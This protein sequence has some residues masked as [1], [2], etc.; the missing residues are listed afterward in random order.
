MTPVSLTWTPLIWLGLGAI[1][2]VVLRARTLKFLR[3]WR[4]VCST[5]CLLC[6]VVLATIV[7]L[8]PSL[9][10]TDKERSFGALF[11][12][13]DSMDP[14]TSS[15]LLLKL[16]EHQPTTLHSFGKN[17]SPELLESSRSF[18]S[19]SSLRSQ[20]SEIGSDKSDLLKAL[21]KLPNGPLILATDGWMTGSSEEEILSLVR[22]RG[23]PIFP[24][25]PSGESDSNRPRV[26]V[27][28]LT[29]P[30]QAPAKTSVAIRAG[31]KNDTAQPQSG[32]IVIRDGEK[33]ILDKNVT[34]SANSELPF[35]A[36]TDADAAGL[37]RIEVS[38]SPSDS[39]YATSKKIAV[40]NSQR[41]ERVLLL[42][43]MVEEGEVLKE[44]LTSQSY[45]L[46]TVNVGSGTIPLF[47]DFSAIILN[48]VGAQQLGTAKLDSLVPFIENGGGLIMVGGNRSFGLGGYRGSTLEPYLPVKLLPPRAE[49]KRINAAVALVL[50]KSNSMGELRKLDYAK[51]AA[52]EVVRNL[53]DD[54]YLSVI[55][56]DNMP[57]V[58]VKMNQLRV[59]RAQAL[60][61]IKYLFPKLGTNLVP[62]M[63]EARRQLITA[64]AGKKHV[65]ILTDGMLRAN[66]SFLIQMSEEFRR[67]GITTSTVLVGLF[68]DNTMS[69]MARLGGGIYHQT[70][71]PTA[72]PRIFLSDIK[73][74]AGE[75]TLR[76]TS[77]FTVSRKQN[78]D[79]ITVVRD[80]PQIQGFVDT[81]PHPQAPPEL[82][83]G[84]EDGDRPLLASWKQGR[85]R[86]IALTTDAAGRW[87]SRWVRWN[88]YAQLWTDLIASARGKSGTESS[89]R[90]D[91]S[92]QQRYG[93]IELDVA[94]YNEQAARDFTAKLNQMPLLF[95]TIAPGHLRAIIRDPVPGTY[96][97]YPSVG[98]QSLPESSFIVDPLEIAEQKG[99]GFNR[100]LLKRIADASGGLV[101][102]SREYLD[103][104]STSKHE[105][106]SISHALLITSV[107]FFLASL[108]LRLWESVRAR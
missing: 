8:D 68:Q 55:G 104:L 45:E 64:K 58:V 93:T 53:K 1:V 80:I 72:L 76:E 97:I 31:V 34:I 15:D 105:I 71:D 50:D 6:S 7:L 69:E 17:L 85:G 75:R 91:L 11:D 22:S 32:R 95:E 4:L 23:T 43:G 106:Y 51:E 46:V 63:D 12:I 66:Q 60:E 61:R 14:D 92:V 9:S 86:V 19:L 54:D 27:S 83:V 18:P 41:R 30:F 56:F 21:E 87:T 52:E 10:H 94:L 42:S 29:V 26:A 44:L 88:Q 35:A 25:T 73:V 5:F 74:N 20:V 82:T 2:S 38:F 100:A 33:I 47:S 3:T 77:D 89:V 99:N 107:V 98:S 48:N 39:S 24:V 96:T 57:F 67:E 37:H 65:I 59:N 103:Q 70:N 16:K 78:S 90:Y 62:A 79:P 81:L 28:N 101:N 108:A 40:I 102:P 49:Q 84:A 36:K 13:S